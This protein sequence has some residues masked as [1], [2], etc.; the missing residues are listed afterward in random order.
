[1]RHETGIGPSGE[2]TVTKFGKIRLTSASAGKAKNRIRL[3]TARN[4]RLQPQRVTTSP[5]VRDGLLL[6]QNG[7]QHEWM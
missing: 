1:M 6:K 7:C 5:G 2:R 3:L 4:E